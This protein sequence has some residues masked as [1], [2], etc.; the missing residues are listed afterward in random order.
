MNRDLDTIQRPVYVVAPTVRV[1]VYDE[2]Q[3]NRLGAIRSAEAMKR[4]VFDL[5]KTDANFRRERMAEL[6]KNGAREAEKLRLPEE[7]TEFARR[8]FA[9]RKGWQRRRVKEFWAEVGEAHNQRQALINAEEAAARIKGQQESERR[10]EIDLLKRIDE[11]S[12]DVRRMPEERTNLQSK[13]K[14][15]PERLQDKVAFRWDMQQEVAEGKR[16]QELSETIPGTVEGGGP[17]QKVVNYWIPY[18]GAPE[19]DRDNSQPVEEPDDTPRRLS[20]RGGLIVAGLIAA[21]AG[22]SI[23]GAALGAVVTSGVGAETGYVWGLGAGGLGLFAVASS[24]ILWW[25]NGYGFKK[26][27]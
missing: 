25:K 4:T 14:K 10:A 19:V 24:A 26:R 17:E 9:A 13:T 16:L 11:M 5:M 20:W 15:N 21:M 27:G 22:A 12:D 8:S 6:W 1:S 7:L 18:Q 3:E 23:S 2:K